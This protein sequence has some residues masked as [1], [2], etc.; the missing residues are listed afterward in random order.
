MHKNLLSLFWLDV[1]YAVRAFSHRPAFTAIVVLTLALGI[2]SSVAIVSVAN[3]VLLQ[4][5][6]FEDPESLVLVW[7]R[8]TAA[9]RPNAPVSGPDFL[10]YRNQTT[11]FEGFA[12]AIAVEGTLTGEARP[13]Q[14]MVGWS[15]ENL[16]ELLGVRPFMGR[17]FE[18]ADGTPID[19]K[20]FLDPNAKL[21]PGVLLLTY[22]MWHRQ[23]GADPRVLGRTIQLDGQASVV[24]G[25][26][27]REFR[28]YLPAYAGMPTN[29]DAWRVLPVDFST[30]PR[31]GEWLTVVSRLKPEVTL[32][33]A[34]AEM[35]A[36]SA[37]FREQFEH[38]KRVGMEIAVHSMH[39]DVVDHVRPLLLTLL[40]AA[41]FVLLIAC[42][43]VANLLLV[44]AAERER[45]I[46]V[47]SALGGGQGRIVAQVLTESGVLAVAGGIVGLA[48]AWG[49][50]R[51]L[52]AMEP[53]NLPRLEAV[54]IDGNV[55]LFTVAAS[56]LAAL[57]FGAVPAL[58]SARPDLAN[59]LK[60]RGSD[61]GGVRGNK[62]RTALVVAEVAL[63]LVLLLG[64]G[65]LV[66]SFTNLKRVEPGFNPENVLTLSVPL[67]MFKYRTED[68]RVS[69]FERLQHR[70]A[71]LPGVDAVGGA[72]PIPLGGGDQY[73][74]QPYAR[75]DGTEEDWNSNRAD[76]RAV[77]PGYTQ[78]MG[79][80]LVAGRPLGDADNQQGALPV[81]VL[82]EKLASQTWPDGDPVGKA[83]QI[84]RFNARE[85]KLERT[86]VQVVGVVEHVRSESLI[87]DGR[88]AIYYP[89]R[90]F[91]WWPMTLTVR[92]TGDPSGLLGAIRAEVE[93]LDPDVP[94]ADVRPMD[95]YVADAMAPTRFTLTLIGL[96]ALLALALACIG[97]YGVMSYSLRQRIQEIGVRLAFGAGARSI[98][99]LIVGHGVALAF[100]GVVLGLV[101]AVGATRM[102]SSLLFGVT[103]T[104]PV[105]FVGIP[106][107]LVAVTALASYIPARRA[108]K[109]DPV[110]A[111]RLGS[112]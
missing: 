50:I 32:E 18:P 75:E 98:V 96:F 65:L 77:L 103:P 16:F 10:D 13:E 20:K 1:R 21:P 38:H 14:V 80:Q 12:G 83:M 47:R 7:N 86:S 70:I 30:N 66:R 25:V 28:L 57:V 44:R 48:L 104:D 54:G 101:V 90:F 85:M 15:T 72:T 31:D 11:M 60:D 107:L 105:T 89:Y 74:V 99:S 106:L 110:S 112:R 58:R 109:I 43:N 6:P 63:S 24:V 71:A 79:I 34:Q 88:G 33:Q 111:L 51:A 2:G 8:M 9:N 100:G 61:A 4:P 59:S 5:L 36:L 46:A 81:V 97:L 45:E 68:M 102:A 92:G 76:Y 42:A 87:A 69:F 84:V 108:T 29:I 94:V 56:F 40:G 52:A 67:P 23:F 73:W 35:D 3:A 55:L 26:L 39:R 22:G 62:V 37:R 19:P 17:D 53:K 95:E 49:G 64:A 82:D 93:G 27:P 78:A 41:G 91:P